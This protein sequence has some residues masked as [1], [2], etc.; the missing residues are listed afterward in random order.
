VT[1]EGD[2]DLTVFTNGGVTAFDNEDEV[3][4]EY[5][6]EANKVEFTTGSV[7]DDKVEF[8]TGSVTAEGDSDLTVFTNGGVTAFDNEDEVFPEYAKEANKV[9]FTTG[10][11]GDD[12]A[13]FSTGSVTAFEGEDPDKTE[14]TTGSVTAEGEE[15]KTFSGGVTA[16]EGETFD[17]K[18][19]FGEGAVTG[20]EEASRPVV[21]KVQA[22]KV[23]DS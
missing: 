6:K 14:F 3:F 23:R 12:K 4:P 7:G 2:S 1:A 9:E 17:G 22:R 13:E 16:F 11:V 8:T 21:S 19:E 18:M 15:V 5:A 10:S 20:E